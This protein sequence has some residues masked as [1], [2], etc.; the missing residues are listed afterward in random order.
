MISADVFKK[1]SEFFI[2]YCDDRWQLKAIPFGNTEEFD[3]YLTLKQ[4]LLRLSTGTEKKQPNSQVN[5]EINEDEFIRSVQQTEMRDRNSTFA[6]GI[7]SINLIRFDIHIVY[8]RTYK[9]P[10]LYFNAYKARKLK[11]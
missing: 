8:S 1:E 11:I 3:Y 10:V 9:V 6:E 7:N 4:P 5:D 2:R